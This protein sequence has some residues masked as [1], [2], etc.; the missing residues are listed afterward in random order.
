MRCF[1]IQT[2]RSSGTRMKHT[3]I[4][5]SA[6]SRAL[7]GI[8]WLDT[9][10]NFERSSIPAGAGT[11]GSSTWDLG[12]MHSLLR[13]MKNPQNQL[14]RVIHVV[15][16]K[17]KGS[18]AVMLDAILQAAGYRVGR[19]SSPHLACPGER[20]SVG[21]IYVCPYYMASRT[22]SCPADPCWNRM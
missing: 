8:Q 11:A 16:T 19:Y 18:S 14:Q 4:K 3:L 13:H 2:Q 12:N 5:G 22:L 6:S 7:R 1:P 20:I 15:G 17:G 21:K 9:L 10:R